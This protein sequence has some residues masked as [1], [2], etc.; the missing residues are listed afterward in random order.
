MAISDIPEYV[1]AQPGD[2]ISAANWNYVQELMRNSLR[3]HKH[4]RPVGTPPTDSDTTDVAAQIDASQ[5]APGAVTSAQLASGA[6]TAGQLANGAVT[7]ASIANGAVTTNAIAS[8]AVNSTK[9]A[10]TTVGQGSVSLGPG[11]SSEVL[12][13][14]AAPSTKTTIYFPTVALV[15]TTGAGTSDVSA[16][17]AY[18]Q[19]VGGNT[20]DVYVRLAN[21]GAGTVSVIWVV[22]T[23]AQ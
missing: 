23:F 1:E 18:K 22:L 13:Q 3:L 9:L 5:I 4:T 12:V 15:S 8:N 19:A 16:Q 2:L 21:S 7:A 17:V 11:A 6:V 20:I 14:S 10:F